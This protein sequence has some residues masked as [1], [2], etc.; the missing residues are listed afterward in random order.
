MKNWF[1]KRRPNKYMFGLHHFVEWSEQT[2]NDPSGEG[3]EF[4]TNDGEPINFYTDTPESAYA[5]L[6]MFDSNVE[7]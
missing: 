2:K 6:N 3:W 1:K 4:F 5:L 7:K